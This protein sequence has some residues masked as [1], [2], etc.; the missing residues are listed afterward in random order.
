MSRALIIITI[1]T[2]IFIPEI[3][4]FS[5]GSKNKWFQKSNHDIIFVHHSAEISDV[6][7]K[8]VNISDAE[9]KIFVNTNNISDK[10]LP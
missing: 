6:D 5:I 2:L 7:Y 10:V 1:N 8:I 4:L 9:K 3:I